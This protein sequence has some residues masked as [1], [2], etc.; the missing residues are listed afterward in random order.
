MNCREF[1][2]RKAS[3]SWLQCLALCAFAVMMLG[4]QLASSALADGIGSNSGKVSKAQSNKANEV[5]NKGNALLKTGNFQQ[6]AVHYREAISLDPSIADYYVN[7]SVALGQ[8][9][10]FK[11]AETAGRKAAQ[12]SP[13]DW[14]VWENLALALHGQKKYEQELEAFDRALKLNPAKA[15]KEEIEKL[16]F[17]VEWQVSGDKSRD[18]M[19]RK[20]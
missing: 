20:K 11:G 8:L 5:Y 18:A 3:R 6:A 15:A 1:G 10:D 13:N 7:L 9:G 17:E 12:M 2:A 16:K 4:V 14:D 19:Y